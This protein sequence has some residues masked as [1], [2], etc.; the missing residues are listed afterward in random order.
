MNP[1]LGK[2]LFG[3]LLETLKGNK[4]AA[5]PSSALDILIGATEAPPAPPPAPVEPPQAVAP[6]PAPLAPAALITQDGEV[7]L[8]SVELALIGRRAGKRAP[9][10]EVDL[11]GYDPLASVSRRHAWIERDSQGHR[12]RVESD[13]P[14]TNPVLLEGQELVPGQSYPIQSGALIQVGLVELRFEFPAPEPAE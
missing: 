8:I 5:R 4:Q 6:Q 13:P 14:P 7:L 1:E 10:P 2:Q 3:N 11:A 12:L 9:A